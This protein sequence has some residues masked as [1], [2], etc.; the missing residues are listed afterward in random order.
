MDNIDLFE[1]K[2]DFQFQD[3]S[4]L[5]EA[6]THRSYLNENK[7]WPYHHNERLEFLGDA[8]LELVITDLLFK[9]YPDAQEGD[10]TL[11]RAALVNYQ[12]LAE[13]AQSIN[14]EKF[15]YLSRGETKDLP[16]SQ[17]VIVADAFEALIGAIYL[18]AKMMAAE[19]FIKNFV[20]SRLDEVLENKSYKDAKSEL[21]EIV[22]DKLKIT[23]VYKILLESGPAHER[24]FESGVYLEEKLIAKGA[25]RAKQES[26]IEAAKAALKK[27]DSGELMF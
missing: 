23:P 4:L 6:L 5:Y 19:K 3:K 20:F 9:Y 8:V 24:I 14:L 22:Q 1:K 11:L 18:D 21:Q 16:K 10:M 25:G 26:E 15:L 7:S 27:I 13:I 12:K 17:E 2:I